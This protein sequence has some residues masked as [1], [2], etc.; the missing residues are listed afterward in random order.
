MTRKK[1]GEKAG[2]HGTCRTS[3]N[4]RVPRLDNH[5]PNIAN[6]TGSCY[7]IS[8]AYGLATTARTDCKGILKYIIDISL[9]FD[10]AYRAI[11]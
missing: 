4:V 8:M 10:V 7:V 9:Y 5:Y 6:R 11:T 1:A 3:Q 2:V